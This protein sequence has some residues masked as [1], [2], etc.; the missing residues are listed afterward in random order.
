[1]TVRVPP[2]HLA[3]LLVLL[4]AAGTLLAGPLVGSRA[5]AAPGDGSVDA[6]DDGSTLKKT[7]DD[8][9]RGY[10]DA[11]AQ[12]VASQQR[13][14]ELATELAALE[15]RLAIAATDVESIAVLAH[16]GGRAA[17]VTALF[18]SGSLQT[19]TDQLSTLDQLARYNA[20]RIGTLQETR[21]AVAAQKTAL[22]AEVTRQREQ[23]TVMAQRVTEAEAALAT[24]GSRQTE[25]PDAG[26][27][28]GSDADSGADSARSGDRASRS[29]PRNSDG[30][31]D[32]ES[33]SQ[34]DPTTGG[35]MTPRLLFAYNETV[36]AGFTRYTR[37]WRESNGHHGAGRACDLAA[38]SDGFGET[39]SGGDKDYG[40]RLAAWYV[41]N[42]DRLGIVY[43]IWFREIWLP[44]VGWRSYD[45]SG[46]P[47]A[48]HTDHVHLSVQ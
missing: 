8:A 37:C 34:D 21:D 4:L 14:A 3:L 7:L 29:A 17:T 41:D 9:A 16:K 48:A 5:V 46:S 19:F 12:L 31:F 6:E 26:S 13:Q 10:N 42:A 27:D 33:C 24:F 36:D 32:D 1:M 28:S 22:D 47:S 18:S 15:S 20:D 43:V 23:E 2:G 44:G 40:D 39:A 25:G 45:G 35:C 30:G 38:S 11:K